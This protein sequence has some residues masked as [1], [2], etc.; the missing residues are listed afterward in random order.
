[1][2]LDSGFAV[3]R[4]GGGGN[5]GHQR[6]RERHQVGL[7]GPRLPEEPKGALVARPRVPHWMELLHI[8]KRAVVERV[9]PH[10]SVVA[11]HVP[12]HVTDTDPV[13]CQLDEARFGRP[14][15]RRD[16][17]W[18]SDSLFALGVGVVSFL[19]RQRGKHLGV[20]P[21]HR[22]QHQLLQLPRSIGVAPGHPPGVQLKMPHAD[23]RRRGA[24]SNGAPLGS[25]H[26]RLA[27]AAGGSRRVPRSVHHLA[28]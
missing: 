1:M 11:V 8:A 4:V 7:H 26:T 21:P 13:R 25:H 18:G 3:S 23:K 22:V 15:Q 5:Q 27:L 20:L 2:A 6:P 19:P 10:R 16:Q 14:E 17:S 12:L 9:P 28:G 24:A